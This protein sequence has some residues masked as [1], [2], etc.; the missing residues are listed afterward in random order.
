MTR[1]FITKCI[2]KTLWLF[3]IFLDVLK[4]LCVTQIARDNIIAATSRNI[5]AFHVMK[6][7]KNE[8]E[9][10]NKIV[11]D[12]LIAEWTNEYDIKPWMA[13]I[14]ISLLTSP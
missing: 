13:I 11:G 3:S 10:A 6:L 7:E 14:S 1:I 5:E 9:M 4:K 12:Q 2:T 8:D